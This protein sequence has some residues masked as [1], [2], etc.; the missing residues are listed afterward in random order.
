[1]VVVPPEVPTPVARPLLL[2]VATDVFDELH[3][4]GLVIVCVPPPTYV[5]VAVNCSVVPPLIVGALGV[6]AIEDSAGT[7]TVVLP[8][9]PLSAAAI[10]VEPAF[11]AVT[12]PVLLT[13]ATA[14]FE[15]VQ[16]VCVVMFSVLLLS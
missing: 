5:P 3:V 9:I 16:V 14:V 10:V 2:I 12:T 8:L 1:M 7:V 13:V 6:T 11:T 4:T 15:E